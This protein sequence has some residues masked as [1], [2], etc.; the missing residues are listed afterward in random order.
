MLSWVQRK[1]EVDDAAEANERYRAFPHS[2][3]RLMHM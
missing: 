2:L 3:Q 1:K